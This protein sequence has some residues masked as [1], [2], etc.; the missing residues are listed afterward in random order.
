MIELQALGAQVAPPT[1]GKVSSPA[2]GSLLM[3]GVET[4]KVQVGG[5]DVWTVWDG[6]LYNGQG[7]LPVALPGSRGPFDLTS[8]ELYIRSESQH[9]TATAAYVMAPVPVVLKTGTVSAGSVGTHWLAIRDC[10]SKTPTTWFVLVKHPTEPL[11]RVEVQD[12]ASGGS[13]FISMEDHCLELPNHSL[14][15]NATQVHIKKIPSLMARV[16][17]AVKRSV[18]QS[19]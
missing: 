16:Q 18:W 11:G 8:G 10:E 7:V 4:D 3:R 13:A 15:A 6:E 17:A 14:P 12:S 2:G 19:T 9:T 5:F 1:D